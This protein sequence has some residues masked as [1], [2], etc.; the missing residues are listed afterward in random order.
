MEISGATRRKYP[1]NA[2]FRHT[3]KPETWQPVTERPP[4][5]VSR[6]SPPSRSAP[7][8]PSGAI[9]PLFVA[10]PGNAELRRIRTSFGYEDYTLNSRVRWRGASC[11]RCRERGDMRWRGATGGRDRCRIVS[12]GAAGGTSGGDGF[13]KTQRA[14]EDISS[15][16]AAARRLC[17]GS[18]SDSPII[19]GD[20]YEGGGF[21]PAGRRRIWATPWMLSDA[22]FFALRNVF[23]PPGRSCRAAVPRRHYN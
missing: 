19:P 20:I 6:F 8:M 3:R 21:F 2:L 14:P 12:R 18:G 13:R 9:L 22:H 11:W 16:R 7:R 4:L 23:R 15:L 5:P 17:D 10:A 1:Q